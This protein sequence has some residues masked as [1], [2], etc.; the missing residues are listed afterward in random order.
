MG[1]ISIRSDMGPVSINPALLRHTT[2]LSLSVCLLVAGGRRA[3]RVIHDRSAAGRGEG[4]GRWF[5][6]LINA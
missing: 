1:S 3:A 5:M 4:W 2:L 6:S